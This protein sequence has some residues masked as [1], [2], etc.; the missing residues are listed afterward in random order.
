MNVRKAADYSA[1]YAA[2][3]TLMA[4]NLPQMETY[5]EIGRLI[6]GRP[7]KGAAVAAAEYLHST[8]PDVSGSS[9][10]N[11]RRMRDFYLTYADAQEIVAEA[12]VIGWTQNVVILEAELTLRERAWYIRTVRQFGWP[13]LKLAERI[14]SSSHLESALDLRSQTCCT[15]ESAVGDRQLDLYPVTPQTGREDTKRLPRQ[16]EDI[17]TSK[18]QDL[19][20]GCERRVLPLSDRDKMECQQHRRIHHRHRHRV[21]AALRDQLGICPGNGCSQREQQALIPRHICH[22]QYGG[23][24]H[25]SGYP[26]HGGGPLP[27]FLGI[28]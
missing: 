25:Q 15:E 16:V 23:R 3:D 14:A 10:R 8:Y 11:L 17:T 21:T 6:C 9:P 1:L 26:G 7:E 12:M 4:L 19:P 5:R 22:D 18:K 27:G 24:P 28:S 13:K 20:F 2:L